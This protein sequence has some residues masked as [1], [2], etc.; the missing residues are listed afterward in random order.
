MSSEAVIDY[1]T[2]D[3][4]QEFARM[5]RCSWILMSVPTGAGL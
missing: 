4:V 5:E 1:Y 2:R 3:I